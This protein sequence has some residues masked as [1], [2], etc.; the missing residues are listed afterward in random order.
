M[1]S[2]ETLQEILNRA[3]DQATRG[4][5]GEA[6]ALFSRALE[7]D[8]FNLEA[9]SGRASCLRNLN[10]TE[11]ARSL[12]D[13]AL[14]RAPHEPRLLKERALIYL[15]DGKYPEALTTSERLLSIT[16]ADEDA[17]ALRIA[18]FRFLRRFADAK[19]ALDDVLSRQPQNLNFLLQRAQLCFEQGQ[20]TNA[21]STC[22]HMLAIAPADE[23]ALLWRIISLRMLRRFKD[24]E[25][26]LDEVLSRHPQN[27]QFLSQR[28]VLFHEQGQYAEALAACEHTLTIAPADENALLL[29]IVVLRMLRRFNDAKKALDN[30]LSVRPENKN[31]L[32]QRAFLH[33]DQ[34]QYALALAAFE[35]TLSLAPYDENALQYRV[36]V[37]RTL[38]RLRDAEKAL[39]VALERLPNSAEILK[40]RGLV[41][42][43][44]WRHAE[45]LEA[46]ERAL[47]IVPY[48]E[49]VLQSRLA[50]LR[51]RRQFEDARDALEEALARQPQSPGIQVE[52]VYI[53]YDQQ[54]FDEA[55]AISEEITH[56]DPSNSQAHQL[57]I[58]CLIR[59]RRYEEASR[60]IDEALVLMQAVQ[61]GPFLFIRGGILEFAG[62]F[63]EAEAA[64]AA[65]MATEP[66]W[67]GP[68]F[69][70][71]Y[72]LERLGRSAEALEFIQTLEQRYPGDPEVADGIGTFYLR[73]NAPL[74]AQRKF[75]E[76]PEGDNRREKGLGGVCATL[77]DYC[78]AET[79]FRRALEN[80]RWTADNHADLAWVLVRQEDEES[81]QEAEKFCRSALDIDREFSPALGCLGVIAF[82]RGRIR[83]SEDWF[84]ASIRANPNRGS[85]SDLGALYVQA[86][87][88]S[89]AKK[90]LDQAIERTPHDVRA[91]IELG[92]LHW[93]LGEKKEALQAL[94]RAMSL[95]PENDQ[96]YRA[97]AVVLMQTGELAETERILRE[98]LQ[99][100][101]RPKQ[102]RLRITLA[103]VLRTTGERGND[104][105]LY[106][107]A[108]REIL[109]ALRLKEE[110]E[111]Y[112]ELGLILAK[113]DNY[114]G[115]LAAFQKCLRLDSQHIEAMRNVTKLKAAIKARKIQIRGGAYGGWILGAISLV[116]LVGI[117]VFFFLKKIEATTFV[118]L[119]PIMLTLSVVSLVLP[120]L[121]RLKLPGVEAE[122]TQQKQSISS[123]PIGD[124]GLISPTPSIT[125]GPL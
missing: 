74:L 123:G 89:E 48:N 58:A 65:A 12:L 86:G 31:Y 13:G 85:Y 69:A 29:R 114:V 70:R 73:R 62:R 79:H 11:D 121:T 93:Q 22:E 87:R 113:L 34:R 8:S 72:E 68:A 91:W 10:R 122:L 33:Q 107:E 106:D 30:A 124:I 52:R 61:R 17:L 59:S 16:P 67:F 64:F 60:A 104:R 9:L 66:V 40:E 1:G 19:E 14:I 117:W 5:F 36:A 47:S 101:D 55:L 81:L 32:N 42:Q 26:A 78:G 2:S 7:L 38:G 18:S 119:M 116:N 27:T 92:N 82:R 111:S 99:R 97:L 49:N 75:E 94:R 57:K 115:A 77:G 98:G 45:A 95:E 37:L 88:Y 118:V 125:R 4:A 43:S 80:D 6:L 102:S 51:V 53:L 3:K 90:K 23:N 100:V 96:T 109:A 105:D 112:F 44:Q 63:S 21:L 108:H 25:K 120:W 46:F 35:H 15:L 110:P 84:L 56:A 71:I 20:Y 54:R 76:I 50:L 24:V 103:Q 39:E 41:Y 28:V 83:E